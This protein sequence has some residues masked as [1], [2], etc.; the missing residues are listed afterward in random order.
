MNDVI[1]AAENLIFLLHWRKAEC[2]GW[3]EKAEAEKVR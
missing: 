3:Q 2:W 1:L